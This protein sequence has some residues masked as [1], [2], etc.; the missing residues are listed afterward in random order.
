MVNF[1][2][3]NR[4]GS[5]NLPQKPESMVLT[6]TGEP[7]N[8]GLDLDPQSGIPWA[9]RAGCSIHGQIR[10]DSKS[11]LALIAGSTEV[12]S[13]SFFPLTARKRCVNRWRGLHTSWWWTLDRYPQ[14]RCD[15]PFK[16]MHR[17]CPLRAQNVQS[18]NA[19][20][21]WDR[22]PAS[23]LRRRYIGPSADEENN[24]RHIFALHAVKTCSWFL[25]R[26]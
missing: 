14:G 3:K 7:S 8:T 6:K 26:R 17:T 22:H 24:S 12:V 16:I 25:R 18:S 13:A 20:C 9:K 5:Q 4:G 19:K 2:K 21:V 10:E 15:E 23:I 1:K 11:G